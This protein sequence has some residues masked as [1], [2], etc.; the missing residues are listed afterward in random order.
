MRAQPKCYSNLRLK[1]RAYHLPG[2]Y[3]MEPVK[4]PTTILA[5]ILIA[6]KLYHFYRHHRYR[7]STAGAHHLSSVTR[8]GDVS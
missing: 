3:Y 5:H 4:L 7:P 8:D 1:G 2:I 6:H